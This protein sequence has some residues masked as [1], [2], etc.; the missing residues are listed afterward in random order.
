[1]LSQNYK[2]ALTALKEQA[3]AATTQLI[4]CDNAKAKA[5]SRQR[6]KEAQARMLQVEREVKIIFK[7]LMSASDDSL[8][9]DTLNEE[10]LLLE[11]NKHGFS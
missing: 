6:L 3:G 8:T 10:R 7:V 5:L 2:D 9:I 4:N 11:L 1:M